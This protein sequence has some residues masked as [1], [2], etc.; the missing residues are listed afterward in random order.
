MKKYRCRV[1]RQY[2][3]E[4]YVEVKANSTEEATIKAREQISNTEL[5]IGGAF[6]ERDEVEEVEE[7]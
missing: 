2:W 3:H 6:P 4:G 5:K 7:V 1:V